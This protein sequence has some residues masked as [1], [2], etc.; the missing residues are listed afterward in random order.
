MLSDTQWSWWS[1]LI[2]SKKDEF[3]FQVL[4]L[5]VISLMAILWYRSRKTLSTLPPGPR[6]FPVVG[7]L[8]FLGANFHH[9]FTKLAQRYGPIFKIQLGSKTYIILSSSDLAK[10]VLHEQDDIFANRDPP[11]AGLVVSYGGKDIV[12]SNNNSYWRN[13]RKVFVHE[14][15][16]NK[17]LEATQSFRRGGVR[18]TIKQVYETMGTEVDI[19]GIVFF[20]SLGVIT[21]MIW[22][23]SLVE[24]E[25]NSDVGVGLREVIS[26]IVQLLGA[27][28]V[29]DFF[30]ML[31][32]FDLQGVQR[33]MKRQW[34]TMDRILERIIEERLSIKKDEAGRKDFLQILLEL[35]QQNT[36]S[37]FTMTEIKALLMDIVVG[38]TDTTSTM[39]E[40]T[41]AELLQNPDEMK[42]VQ[43][44]LEQVIGKNNIV[45]ES[46]LPKLRYLDAVIKETF[47]LHPPLPLL[48][49]RSPKL[50]YIYSAIKVGGYTIPKGSNVYLNVWAIHRDPQYWENPLEFDPNRFLMA[51]GRN[52]YD[53]SGYNTN[54]LPFGS[55]RRGCP[56]VPLGEKMLLY[57]LASLLHS[58][59]WILPNNKEHELSDKFGLVVKKRNPLMAIPSQRLPD[60]NLYM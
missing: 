53:Y 18:K 57:L 45:E 51:D 37:A 54:F 43:E 5:S 30:P 41:M 31:T 55:G 21:S 56:G 7:Y 28:N 39:A 17:N 59:N 46:H 52:K 14:V 24:D 40:W 15:L 29:S 20:T 16:S 38:G 9:E 6:G 12:W 23:K 58:F 4:T 13:L 1:E 60:K 27:P 22:G 2:T 50:H 11:V 10:A 3:T 26:K 47:R 35:K 36:A 19:G 48:I 34:K 42:K 49:M 44:E 25:K 32:K 33:E 8:P